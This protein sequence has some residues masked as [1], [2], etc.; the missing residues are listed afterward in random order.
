MIGHI[1]VE[2]FPGFC[3]SKRYNDE[4][5][6]GVHRNK[7]SHITD[8]RVAGFTVSVLA[9]HRAR[10]GDHLLRYVL[11]YFGVGCLHQWAIPNSTL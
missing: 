4:I 1:N 2:V 9:K 6:R 8:V 5:S 11:D 10:L 3:A 7:S